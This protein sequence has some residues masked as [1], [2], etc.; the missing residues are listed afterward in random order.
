M[1]SYFERLDTCEYD[2]SMES[3][4]KY[5]DTLGKRAVQLQCRKSSQQ[6]YSQSDRDNI[7]FR[8]KF[9]ND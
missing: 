8:L 9:G 3:G 4:D 2:Q 7:D 1:G 6:L 5:N